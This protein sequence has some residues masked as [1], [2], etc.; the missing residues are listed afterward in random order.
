VRVDQFLKCSRLIKHRAWAKLACEKRKVKLNGRLVKPA[1]PVKKGDQL[2][3]ELG[4]RTLKVE[5]LHAEKFPLPAEGWYRMLEENVH[6]EEI[7]HSN[8]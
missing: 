8:E 3:L 5:I 1:H 4:N 7:V 2:A 6:S